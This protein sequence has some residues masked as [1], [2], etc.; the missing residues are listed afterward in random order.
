MCTIKSIFYSETGLIILKQYLQNY[1]SNTCF[2]YTTLHL[3][4]TMQKQIIN[5]RNNSLSSISTQTNKSSII[6]L[7]AP[8]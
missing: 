5:D 3:T 1:L 8:K 7:I 2:Y 4:F 6:T